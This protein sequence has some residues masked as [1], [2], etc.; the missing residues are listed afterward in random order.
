MMTGTCLPNAN[1]D[2]LADDLERRASGVRST[3]S[4][5]MA[6]PPAKAALAFSTMDRSGRIESSIRA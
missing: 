2:D 4:W 1:L 3:L 5:R 6:A